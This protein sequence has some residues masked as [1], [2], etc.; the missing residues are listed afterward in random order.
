MIVA[1]TSVLVEHLR[2]NQDVTGRLEQEISRD[3]LLVPA[4]V[5][6]EL[7]K[8]AN[9]AAQMQAVDRLLEAARPDPF[10]PAMA[11]LAAELHRDHRRQGIERPQWD[12]LIASHALHHDAPMVTVDGDF[13]SI[14]G[15]ETI[16]LQ[17]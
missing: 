13:T 7:W 1:D 5:A 3:P 11:A 2:G 14:A 8:G 4:L 17:A 12:L 16:E 10:V 6:W 9:S 15:L